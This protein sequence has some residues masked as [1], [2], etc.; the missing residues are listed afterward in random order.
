MKIILSPAK[1]L[2]EDVHVEGITPSQV[3]FKEE[4]ARLISKLQKLSKNQIAKLMHIS[5]DLADLNYHRFQNFASEF[6]RDN[7][8]PAG[9]LFSGAAYQGL[10]FGSLSI[11]NQEEGNKRLRILSGLYGLLRPFDLIQPYRLEMGTSFKVTPKIT[12]LYKFWGEK[13]QNRLQQE[14]EEEDSKL[15]VNVASAEYFKA[16]NLQN[17]KGIEVIT[18]VFKDLNKKGEFKVNMTYAKQARGMMTRFIIEH[19]IDKS[20]DLKSFNIK[21]YE[22][23]ANS[24]SNTELVFHRNKII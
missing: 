9:L 13:I 1:S 15:L 11:E 7:S 8:S 17:L 4:V 24:S 5:D 20:E 21:G 12:N 6:K 23:D 22:F 19:K 14:L 18:P 10:D 16:A 3:I 2:F